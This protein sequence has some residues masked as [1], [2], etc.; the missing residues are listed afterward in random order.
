[1]SELTLQLRRTGGRAL[2]GEAARKTFVPALVAFLVVLLFV[3]TAV[4]SPLPQMF[5]AAAFLFLA[6][7][8][9]VADRRIPN[10]LTFPALALALGYALLGGAGFGVGTALAGALVAL[11][12][13]G[14]PFAL[15]FLGAGD[16]KACMALGALWGPGALFG[17]AWWMVVTGGVLAIVFV[18]ARGGLWDLVRRWSLSLFYSV[19][20]GRITYFS[21]DASSAAAGGLPF[22]VAIGIGASAFQYWGNPWV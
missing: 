6:I 2:F 12:L 19:R 11:L 14:V 3:R 7:A 5:G 20:L 16:V 13:F 21:P 4:E 1:M 8:S 15:G 17:A 10:V 22:A 18:A 9:D